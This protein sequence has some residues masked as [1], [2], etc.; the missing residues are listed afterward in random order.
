MHEFG[1]YTSRGYNLK[2]FVATR[3]SSLKRVVWA[4]DQQN[5]SVAKQ[6]WAKAHFITHLRGT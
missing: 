6:Y 5:W 1:K 3:T 2:V 4:L